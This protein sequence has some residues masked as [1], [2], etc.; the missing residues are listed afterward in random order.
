M[1]KKII[2]WS[3]STCIFENGEY[4]INSIGDSVI[5]FAEITIGQLMVR[6]LCYQIFIKKI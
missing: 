6:V 1:Q 2:I 4:L 3:C 5:T